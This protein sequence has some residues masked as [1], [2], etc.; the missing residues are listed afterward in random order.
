LLDDFIRLSEHLT[1]VPKLDRALAEQYLRRFLANPTHRARLPGL[2]AAIRRLADR[3]GGPAAAIRREI[4]D[5]ADLGPAAR[6]LIYLWYV[7]AFFDPGPD[8]QQRSRGT[9][10]YG[11][12]PDQY[13]RGLI[14]AVI[15]AH[16]PMTPDKAAWSDPPPTSEPITVP[17]SGWLRSVKRGARA[18]RATPEVA[19]RPADGR[20]FDV[21]VVGSGV[22]GSLA[23]YD[24]AA[25]GRSVLVL[26][27]GDDR[28]NRRTLA[29]K[30]AA[31]P[32]K[33]AHSPYI[34]RVAPQPFSSD[35]PRPLPRDG[36][37]GGD[38]Y[39]QDPAAPPSALFQSYYLNLA[40][41]STWHWQGLWLR[42]LPS[43][44]RLQSSYGVGTDW[45]IGYDDLE[46]WY[47]EAERLVGVA[48]DSTAF[49]QF[50][51]GT[52]S[53]PFPM[54]PIPPSY[55]DRRVMAALDGAT[56]V[57]PTTSEVVELR[58]TP[59]PQAKNSRAYDGRAACEGRSSCIPLCPI[60]AKYEARIHLELARRLGAEVRARCV[61]TRLEAGADNRVSRVRYRRW[62]GPEETVSGRVVVLAA[63]GVENPKLLLLSRTPA[64]PAGL[65]N[66]SDQVG[67]NLMDHPIKVAYAL[68]REPV[69]PFRGPPSTVAI[70]SL[71]DGEFRSF[72]G[73][74]RTS[75]R[76][77]GWAY[78]TG[79]PR[80]GTLDPIL[81]RG[82]LLDLVGN[83][84]LF[85]RRLTEEL[86]EHVSRQVLVGSSV[87]MLPN[88]D[89]RVML[90]P[91]RRDR[92]GIP[93]P[94]IDFQ[95]DR[96]DPRAPL[97]AR[98]TREAFGAANRLHDLA[99]DAMG[100][101]ERHLLSGPEEPDGGAG[102]LMG[103]T[104]MGTDPARSVVDAN[105]LSHDHPNLYILGSSVFPTA[106]SANPT[107]TIAAL[108][109][110]A[111]DC[112]H[113]RL[114]AG[115]L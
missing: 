12:N 59:I 8:N 38:Y 13:G 61:V 72:R 42:M 66:S 101:T 70:E 52:P 95:V 77:D 36:Q 58:V 82:T 71:R 18:R 63:N 22:A 45:P 109:L 50:H 3:P 81:N 1:G 89:N 53:L 79:A 80:G 68:A 28:W 85:G 83:R 62:E 94:E 86:F 34:G 40:G 7:S 20:D 47:G 107:A 76:N 98:Y 6:Q 14:W 74:F 105:C 114:S 49:D 26:E 111:A 37:F 23:A 51:G 90:H 54:P 78:A 99:F 110:R 113:G 16:A 75:F 91:T 100:V 112:I 102:H 32:S 30:F 17:P 87:E 19:D 35:R 97:T 10:R 88:P 39:V 29:K 108:A 46:R 65:A 15:R 41:G 55:A 27:A 9:W 4:M 5:D 115:A 92:F 33:A 25:R 31:S 11:K 93:R 64:R 48:G 56:F 43:D 2:I 67:R 21:I 60:D 44:F 57:D 84:G 103:T 104:I 106:T 96:P 73:A 69:Y 24:L